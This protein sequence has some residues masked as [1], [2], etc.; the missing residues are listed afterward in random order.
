MILAVLALISFL[1][2][3]AKAFPYEFVPGEKGRV[4]IYI[5]VNNPKVQLYSLPPFKIYIKEKDS[6]NFSKDFYT[7][8]DLKAIKEKENRVSTPLKKFPALIIPFT[9]SENATAGVHTVK[10]E[11]EFL[12]CSIGKKWCIKTKQPFSFKFKIKSYVRRKGEL[13]H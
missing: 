2:I 13:P 5:A 8:Y 11:M 7:A 3:D 12:V 9:A 10:C 1:R 6:L 4:N